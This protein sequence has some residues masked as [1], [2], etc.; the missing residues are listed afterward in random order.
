MVLRE[1]KKKNKKP[2]SD[3]QRSKLTLAP[4]WSM[5][6]RDLRQ[7]LEKFGKSLGS[8]GREIWWPGLR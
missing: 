4:A 7:G 3:V 8:P 6:C 2:P 1:K 5:V